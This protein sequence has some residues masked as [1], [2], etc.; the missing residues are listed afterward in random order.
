MVDSD[1]VIFQYANLFWWIASITVNLTLLYSLFWP[2]QNRE[3]FD[4]TVAALYMALSKT[5]WALCLAY[6]VFA[7]VTGNGGRLFFNSSHLVIRWQRASFS[8]WFRAWNNLTYMSQL[9]MSN[10]LHVCSKIQTVR[11]QTSCILY[12]QCMALYAWV[13]QGRPLRV[14]EYTFV[15]P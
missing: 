2:Y 5:A 12:F 6:I 8:S 7:C 13:M 3:Q 15:S 11:R 4:T 14:H 1:N 9:M 10:I